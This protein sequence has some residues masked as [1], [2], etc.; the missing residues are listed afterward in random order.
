MGKTSYLMSLIASITTGTAYDGRNI[1]LYNVLTPVP[2]SAAAATKAHWSIMQW[3][4]V[5]LLAGAAVSSL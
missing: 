5:L 2:V 1:T 4:T 3:A